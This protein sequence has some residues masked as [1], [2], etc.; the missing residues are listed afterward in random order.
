MKKIYLSLIVLLC[1]IHFSYAQ[2]NT[3]PSSGYV[4]IGTTNPFKHLHVLGD[5]LAIS[6]TD[7]NASGTG[8]VIIIGQNGAT[9]NVYSLI[10]AAQNGPNT[11]MVLS[12]NPNGG[13]VG[14]GTAN[15]LH[16][17]DVNGVIN[18]SAYS[19]NTQGVYVDGNGGTSD[20]I[21]SDA[22]PGYLSFRTNDVD[23]RMVIDLYGNIGMGTT[24]PDAKLAVKG[25]IHSTEVKVDLNVPGPDYVFQL[26]YKLNTLNEIKAYIE[27]NHH[28]PEMPSADQMAKDGLNLGEMNT[29]L[30]KKVEELTLYAIDQQKKIDLLE[31]QRQK[32]KQQQDAR[33]AALEKVLSTLTNK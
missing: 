13:S 3:F 22:G 1:A 19:T 25:T 4:G 24:T 23:N 32:D 27:K 2:T 29:K 28:L 10:Q 16:E 6:T 5:N 33:I 12:L 30:L 8:S 26:D 20:G 15:P 11:G 31:Q 7:F 17:L 21:N 18:T 9:G 14:I